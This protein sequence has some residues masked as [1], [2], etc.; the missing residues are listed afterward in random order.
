MRRCERPRWVTCLEPLASRLGL[1]F[2]LSLLFAA[3]TVLGKG[4]TKK[5]DLWSLR[6]VTR[7]EIPK[8]VCASAN[9]IDAFLAEE[10][11]EQGLSPLGP[12]DKLTWLRRV[13]FDLIGL[14]P[15][16]QEQ[17]AFLA[18]DSAGAAS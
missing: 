10:C 12:A 1:L 8:N 9:P 4:V 3:A 7:P 16:V 6:P 13:S 5:E 15:S 17:D 18:D 14:P 11:R 2:A